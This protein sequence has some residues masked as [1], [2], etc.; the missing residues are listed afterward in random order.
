MMM[1]PPGAAALS[2]A[3]PGGAGPQTAVSLVLGHP[4]RNPGRHD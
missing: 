2:V 3:L 1:R 4:K